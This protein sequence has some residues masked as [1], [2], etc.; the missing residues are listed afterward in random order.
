MGYIH[1]SDEMESIIRAAAVKNNITPAQE[2]ERGYNGFT[3]CEKRLKEQKI[4]FEKREKCIYNWVEE[5]TT[6]LGMKLKMEETNIF[7]IN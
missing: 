7:K 2:I 5:K 6:N 3:A 1:I 4:Y